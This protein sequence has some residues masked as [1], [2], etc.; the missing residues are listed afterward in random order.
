MHDVKEVV[1]FFDGVQA[2]SLLVVAVYVVGAVLWAGEESIEDVARRTVRAVLATVVALG[3][4]GAVAAAGG[5]DAA[6]IKFHQIVFHNDYWQLDP[7]RDHLV[8]MFPEG[9][10]L[11]ATLLLCGLIA[12][13]C[14][15]LGGGSWLFVLHR[16]RDAGKTSEH[17]DRLDGSAIDE[18]RTPAHT[19]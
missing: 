5:F 9:F 10:W 8:Q 13:Q 6:F 7:A 16:T 18:Q 1:R 11:F 3:L 2:W 15:V 19:V 12:L 4:F 14:L 17:G